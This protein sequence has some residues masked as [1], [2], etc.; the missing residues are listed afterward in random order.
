MLKREGVPLEVCPTSNLRTGVVPRWE[1]HPL[2]GLVRSGIRTTLNS[3][4][5]SLFRTSLAE[6][7]R[8]VHRRLGLSPRTLYRI[9]RQSIQASFLGAPEKERLLRE[10]GRIWKKGRKD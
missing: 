7:Y 4:D 9:H 2:P 3:D 10:S 8:S 6:E 5:P 1:D